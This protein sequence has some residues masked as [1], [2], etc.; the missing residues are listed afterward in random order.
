MGSGLYAVKATKPPHPSSWAA[1]L[2]FSYSY[3][4]YSILLLSIK[5]FEI[6]FCALSESKLG[7]KITWTRGLILTLWVLAW[8]TS[9]SLRSRPNYGTGRLTYTIMYL[10]IMFLFDVSKQCSI[11]EVIF[12][13]RADKLPAFHVVDLFVHA[14]VLLMYIII[15]QLDYSRIYLSIAE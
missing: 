6:P 1:F 12:A 4:F 8:T 5:S 3:C 13:T 11:A 7:L 9:F 2:V 10:A 14:V 15:F